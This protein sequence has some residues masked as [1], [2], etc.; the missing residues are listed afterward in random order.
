M[1]LEGN[2]SAHLRSHLVPAPRARR[3]PRPRTPPARGSASLADAF[4]LTSFCPFLYRNWPP[5]VCTP[6]LE[7]W[8][9]PGPDPSFWWPGRRRRS[10]TFAP[11]SQPP[12]HPQPGEGHGDSPGLRLA[13]SFFPFSPQNGQDASAPALS[14]C[15]E[16][17]RGDGQTASASVGGC[18]KAGPGVG[19]VGVPEPTT[20]PGPC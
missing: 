2:C 18:G 14:G 6:G 7:Q 19:G 13:R 11:R 1:S 10:P 5:R 3:G 16:C 17:Q 9:S 12:A 15:L 20:L 4:F 8:H